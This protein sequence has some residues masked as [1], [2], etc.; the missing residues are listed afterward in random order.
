MKPT[1]MADL[2]PE[3]QQ[4]YRTQWI[5]RQEFIRTFKELCQAFQEVTGCTR[6][7]IIKN[8]IASGHNNQY[9]DENPMDTTERK[10]KQAHLKG[11]MANKARRSGAES[12]MNAEEL[13]WVIARMDLCVKR[14]RRQ[15]KCTVTQAEFIHKRAGEFIR[16]QVFKQQGFFPEGFP[17]A[18]WLLTAEDVAG[19]PPPLTNDHQGRLW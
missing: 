15:G 4:N 12:L 5:A 1:V 18:Q 3:E 17:V 11:K 19:D 8:F 14:L 16:E 2:S 10:I 6:K 13:T 7:D 9:D